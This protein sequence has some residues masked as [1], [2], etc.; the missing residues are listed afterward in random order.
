VLESL[1]DG[2]SV[3][4]ELSDDMRV[5]LVFSPVHRVFELESRP[6]HVKFFLQL[7]LL[8][9]EISHFRNGVSD[10]SE[11][12]L[13]VGYLFSIGSVSLAQVAVLLLVYLQIFGELIIFKLWN[14]HPQLVIQLL[15]LESGVSSP[16]YELIDSLVAVYLHVTHF[17]FH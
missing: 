9:F 17:N 4:L 15:H 7:I 1:D 8:F 16:S 6:Q 2:H 11:L 12:D 13:E 14:C 10:L 5:E 3:A